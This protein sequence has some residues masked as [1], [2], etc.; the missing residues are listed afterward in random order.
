MATAPEQP[1]VTCPGCGKQNR[2]NAKFCGGC[3]ESLAADVRCTAC[4]TSNPPG[5]RYCDECGRPVGGPAPEPEA[6][7]LCGG[8]YRVLRFLGEGGRKLV[9]LAEDT[10]LHREVAVAACKSDGLDRSA[11]ARTRR[12]AEAMARLSDHPN[13]VPIYDIVEDDELYL[14]SQ[15]MPGGDLDG[16]LAATDNRQLPVPDTVR[17]A[18]EVARALEHAHA[19]RFVHRDVK[20]GNVWL[21]PDGTAKLGDFGLAMASDNQQLT[22][23]GTMIGTVAYM[24]PEQGL[25]RPATARSD[26]YSL[27]ALVYE[28]LCGGPPFSGE[29]SAAVISQHVSR[30]PVRPTWHREDVPRV[31]ENLV[32]KM[33]EKDP[34]QR[35]ESAADVRATLEAITSSASVAEPDT[36]AAALDRL[37]EGTFLGREAETQELR[38]TVDGA[39][40]GRGRIAMVVGEQGI[41]K[42]RLAGEIETYSELRGAVVLW[43][44]CTE[45]E[46]AP[47]YWPW[48]QAIRS[49][50]RTTD[51]EIVRSELGSGASDIA[52]IVSEVASSDGVD[53]PEPQSLD[54][55]QARFRLFDSVTGFLINAARR[56]P[57]VIVLDDLHV[58]DAPSLLLLRFLSA[59]IANARLLVLGTYRDTDLAPDHP[60]HETEAAVRRDRGY[61]RIALHGLT[62]GHVKALVEEAAHQT[63]EMPDELALVKAV[64]AQSEGNPYFTQEIIRHLVESGTIYQEGDRWI[65][66]AKR[67]EDLGI[68]QGIRAAVS[69]RLEALSQDCRALLTTAAVI[70]REFRLSVLEPV[71]ELEHAVLMERLGEALDAAIVVP[72]PDEVGRYTFAHG[73]TRDALYEAPGR[74]RRIELHRQVAETLEEIYEDRIESHLGELAHHFAAAAEAGVADK[75]ADYSWWAGER[76][77]QVYAYEDAVEHLRRAIALFAAGD[78][79]LTR[80]C[81]L[82]L[83]LGDALWRAGDTEKARETFVAAADLAKELSLPE[84]YG[85]AALGYGGGAGGFSVANQ[86]EEQLIGL[87]RTALAMLPERDSVLRVRLTARLAVELHYYSGDPREPEA[88]SRQAVEMADRIGDARLLLLATY[89]RQWATMGPDGLEER[90]AAGEEIIRLAR[91][92]DDEEMAFHGHHLRLIALMELADLQ[93][94]DSEI[95]ACARLARELRQPRYEWQVT[96]FRAMRAVMQGRFDEGQRLADSAFA[97][98]QRGLGEVA[99]V[100]FGAHAFMLRWADGRLAELKEGGEMFAATYRDSAWPAAFAFLLTE[101]DEIDEARERF[102]ALAAGGFAGIRRDSNWLTAMACLSVASVALEDAAAGSRLHELLL[103]YAEGCVP[104]LSGVGC[105]GSTHAYLGFAAHA[106]GR[107]DDAIASYERALEENARIGAAFLAPLIRRHLAFARLTRAAGDD[108]EG[109]LDQIERGL[110]EAT[111]LGE[112]REGERLLALKLEHTTALPADVKTSI[113]Q[114]A[115]SVDQ[116][117]PDLRPVAAPDGTV[118]IMFSDIENSTV[119]TQSLGDHGWLAML[120]THNALVRESCARHGGFEVRIQGDGFMFAFSSARNAILCAIEIQSTLHA[121]RERR[122]EEQLRVRIGL[123]T[124][125]VMR[126]EGDF[127]GTNVNF[128]ARVADSASANE[129]LVSSVLRDLVAPTGEF[130]FDGERAVEFK[131]FHGRHQLYLIPWS[132]DSGKASAAEAV[133]EVPS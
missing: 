59:E 107:L 118:T 61:A 58:A 45:S 113:E 16:L 42:T 32:L 121:H 5:Q 55:E 18:T 77:A 105:M 96:S 116:S 122:P 30:T 37:S 36:A 47:S 22:K 112:P 57:V 95:R 89:S 97:I 2:A 13:I 90:L 104:I 124:G 63:L 131:G 27:G 103:P 17:I 26:I 8:R 39:I 114:V 40:A 48:I 60:L 28:L 25:G 119:L 81:E 74:Q 56:T 100:V 21:A 50:V 44:R 34:A 109:A 31:L 127:Y 54:V 82:L 132:E 41:G 64:Y 125:E 65:S 1:P 62:E 101:I 23:E 98:G 73:A 4:G 3:G 86:A 6:R 35:P 67:I 87:L 53:A 111:A 91:L 94:V 78:D 80:R 75:A 106:A 102:A 15:Y 130:R 108:R 70:G 99:M 88:L 11:L 24:S 79:D 49:Y 69:R 133:S 93:A 84:Q 120:R 38:A 14:V 9:Y 126:D 115:A 51:P 52:Q 29:D 43:G 46:G 71:S 72:A 85:R 20:P 19:N 110:E 7:T 68:P 92:A 129:I 12:E 33:L 66:D 10:Q 76:A 83:A 123:H 128:A 117:R